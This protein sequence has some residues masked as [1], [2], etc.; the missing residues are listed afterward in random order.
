MIVSGKGQQKQEAGKGRKSGGRIMLINTHRAL[1]SGRHRSE[2]FA[3]I[4]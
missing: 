1:A 4:H 2:C 3:D